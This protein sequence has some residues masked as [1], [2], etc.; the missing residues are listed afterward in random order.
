ML[1]DGK[2]SQGVNDTWNVTQNRKTDVDEQVRIAA[3]LEEDTEGRED[4]GKDDF[5]DVTVRPNVLAKFAKTRVPLFSWTLSSTSLVA[6][7]GGARI[8]RKDG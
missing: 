3:A 1:R 8:L 2:Y 6:S 7:F 4:D 5:A